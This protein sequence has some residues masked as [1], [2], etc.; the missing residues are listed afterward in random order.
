M[1]TYTIPINKEQRNFLSYMVTVAYTD[2]HGQ[3]LISHLDKLQKGIEGENLVLEGE[4]YNRTSHLATDKVTYEEKKLV[5]PREC[6]RSEDKDRAILPGTLEMVMDSRK[7][8]ARG[9][10][11][12]TKLSEHQ[13]RRITAG[14][15][16]LMGIRE[17]R[18][19]NRSNHPVKRYELGLVKETWDG[20]WQAMAY[21]EPFRGTYEEKDFP[22]LKWMYERT[23]KLTKEYANGGNWRPRFHPIEAAKHTDLSVERTRNSM[24]R[25]TG[26]LCKITKRA[27]NV[28]MHHRPSMDVWMLPANHEDLALEVLKENYTEPKERT[29]LQTTLV[30]L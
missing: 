25:L 3:I 14:L 15:Y 23:Q 29:V 1:G 8:M 7:L 16:G 4:W 11:K 21:D 17:K 28:S 12:K 18:F 5:V 20:L 24:R 9:W 26:V 6:I 19:L 13:V 27:P 22:V 30:Q 2:S 10:A